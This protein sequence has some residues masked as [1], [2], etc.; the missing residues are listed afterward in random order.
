VRDELLELGKE[1]LRQLKEYDV[2]AGSDDDAAARAKLAIQERSMS[3]SAPSHH[4][5]HAHGHSHASD[6]TSADHTTHHTNH[7]SI[8]V[9]IPGMAAE[10]QRERVP[11]QM[12]GNLRLLRMALAG[13]GA[14]SG[15]HQHRGG[16]AGGRGSP[17]GSGGGEVGPGLSGHA[18]SRTVELAVSNAL[19]SALTKPLADV[20]QQLA[21]LQRDV[22][23]Q[24]CACAWTRAWG[25]HARTARSHTRHARALSRS[26]RTPSDRTSQPQATSHHPCSL[27]TW[28]VTAM[29]TQLGMVVDDPGGGGSAGGGGGGRAGGGGG[30]PSWRVLANETSAATTEG[31]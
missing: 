28:Q 26:D 22:R 4:S 16:G 15:Q 21:T 31:E 1:R 29:K 10:P 18:I 8:A 2:A 20:Q 17:D 6:A 3:L 30:Q 14:M 24:A 25:G 27:M 23:T 5:I 13:S 7:G 19:T 11:D 9:A 12:G